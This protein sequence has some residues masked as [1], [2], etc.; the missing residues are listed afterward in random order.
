MHPLVEQ[1]LEMLR[2]KNIEFEPLGNTS[3][4]FV[5]KFPKLKLPAGW[6][7]EETAIWMVVP[8]GY[9]FAAP[10][11]FWADQGLTLDNGIPPQASGQQAVPHTGEM[12]TW[13]SW[14][15]S[16]WNP[17]RDSLLS[18]YRLIERRLNDVR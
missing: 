18:F 2:N 4:E 3:G 15:V 5:L 9:P 16:G 7:K 11:C 17:N 10:D 12:A 8:A 1:Q 14:H 6:N 13:F